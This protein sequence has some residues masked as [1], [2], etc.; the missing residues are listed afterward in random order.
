MNKIDRRAFIKRTGLAG[1][2]IMAGYSSLSAGQLLQSTKP[3][4]SNKLNIKLL[5]NGEAL[6]NPDMGWNI[7]YYTSSDYRAYGYGLEPSDTV[8]DFPG[9]SSVYLRLPWS[10]L[11]PEEGKFMW[12]NFD[13]PAQRWI[14]KGKQVCFRVMTMD[15]IHQSTPEWVFAA[16][17]KG[18]PVKMT[19]EMIEP[20]YDDPIYLEKLDNFVRA[21]ALRYDG[22]PSV[23][24]VDV[25]FGMWGEGHT[26][27]T[28]RVHGHKWGFETHKKTIDIYCRHFKHTQLVISDDFDDLPILNRPSSDWPVTDYALSRGITLRDDSI[29]VEKAPNQW[30]HA[31]MAEQFWPSMPVIIEHDHYGLSMRHGAWDPELLVKS[32]EAYHGSYMSVHWWPRD[33]LKALGNHIDRINRRLGYRLRIN[34]ITLPQTIKAGEPFIIESEWSNAGVAPCYKGG[35]PCFTLKDRKGGI[36]AVL[37]DESFDVKNLQIGE[38]GKAPVS[39]LVSVFTIANITHLHGKSLYRYVPANE[40]EL[41]VSV[42]RRDG[43]PIYNLPYGAHDG[44]KRYPIGTITLVNDNPDP[45]YPTDDYCRPLE[46]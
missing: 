8:E 20:D 31:D 11:E 23:C 4:S 38:E 22:N 6:V 13:T 43:T 1:V 9:V 14:E 33:E 46:K 45:G 19:A 18:I 26:E 34:E 27:L 32:V 41:F 16:G 15:N 40:Y 37:V 25:A 2:G 36:V 5:D 42:G 17:A 7:Y 24:F 21:M 10:F 28:S 39:R 3:S 35:F 30:H 12:E 44:Y 29:L